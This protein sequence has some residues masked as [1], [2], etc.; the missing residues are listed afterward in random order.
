[1]KVNFKGIFPAITA[2]TAFILAL[3]CLF[4]GSQTSLL[5]DADLL[6]VC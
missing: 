1:M 4:A 6:T 5:D 2:F 3:L